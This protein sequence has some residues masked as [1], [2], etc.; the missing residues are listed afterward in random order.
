MKQINVAIAGLG[1]V[2]RGTYEILTLQNDLLNQRSKSKISLVAVSSRSKKDFVDESKIKFYENTLDLADAENVDVIIEAIGGTEGTALDLCRKTLKNKKHYI[3]ANKAMIA[4]HGFELAKLA[5]ENGV[6][7]AFEA[8]IAAAIPCVKNT[9][10]G[11]SGNKIEKIYAILNGTGNFILT[12]MEHDEADFADALKEAQELGYAEADPTFDIEGI[13]TAHKIALLA[14]IAKNSIVKF[15]G[16][17]IEGITKISLADIKNANELGYKI[18]LCGIFEDYGDTIKQAV[19][20]C[21]IEKSNIIA[22]VS[23]SYNC[24]ATLADNADWN[25]QVGRGAGSKPTASAI[26]ADLMDIANDRLSEPFG[27]TLDKL[28]KVEFA[29]M[30]DRNGAYYLRFFAEQEFAQ[31]SGFIKE[32]FEEGVLEESIIEENEEGKVIYGL[33]TTNLN[34]EKMNSYVQKLEKID[35]ISQINLIRIKNG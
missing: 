26:I 22:N 7:I 21:L 11:L 29:K 2:G 12:K 17:H 5:E 20:P 25:W 28:N 30:S 23:D 16:M 34:E 6:T 35:Q 24:V 27:A 32:V 31:N 1:T 9:K 10:E 14:A 18:K 19:Y 4:T 13:D 33:K 3:T 15:D 8:A